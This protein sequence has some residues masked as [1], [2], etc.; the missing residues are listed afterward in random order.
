MGS[1]CGVGMSA[2]EARDTLGPM[3]SLCRSS[4]VQGFGGLGVWGFRV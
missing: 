1:G 4:G 3:Y 2:I